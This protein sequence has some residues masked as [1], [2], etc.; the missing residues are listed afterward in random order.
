MSRG[1]EEENAKRLITL[2]YLN[3]ILPMIFD[4]ESRQN[5]EKVIVE[6]V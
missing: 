4:E 6:R 1:I 5:V 3:P 2:G